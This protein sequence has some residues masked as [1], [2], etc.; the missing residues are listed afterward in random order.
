MRGPNR[1]RSDARAEPAS[2]E[3]RGAPSL[4][5]TSCCLALTSSSALDAPLIWPYMTVSFCL[6]LFCR[7]NEPGKNTPC[8][9]PPEAPNT[10]DP[11]LFPPPQ[12][13]PACSFLMHARVYCLHPFRGTAQ[14]RSYKDRTWSWTEQTQFSAVQL[15]LTCS[16]G[17]EIDTAV[18]TLQG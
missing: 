10:R 18:P 5:C 13:S 4:T 16:S 15:S 8:P 12:V 7:E 17:Q 2:P 1:S 6:N 9:R 14:S 11:Q 3:G